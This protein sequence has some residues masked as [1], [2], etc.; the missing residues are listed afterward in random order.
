MEMKLLKT[1]SKKKYK[2]SLSKIDSILACIYK[3][4]LNM[5][6]ANLMH[7]QELRNTGLQIRRKIIFLLN[8][9]SLAFLS[10]GCFAQNIVLVE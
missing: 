6:I 5:Q 1:A 9:N 8:I 7:K 10:Y 4:S 3:I 2:A